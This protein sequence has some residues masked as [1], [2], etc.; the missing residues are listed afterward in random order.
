MERQTF[1]SGDSDNT[2]KEY[3]HTPLAHSPILLH[4]LSQLKHLDLD[5]P[6]AFMFQYPLI[7]LSVNRRSF[8]FIDKVAVASESSGGSSRWS[9]A[10]L[11]MGSVP[12]DVAVCTATAHQHT[13]PT[14]E[15]RW[16]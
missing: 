15:L 12:G 4:L 6:L 5:P 1:S 8:E 3:R 13:A 2:R 10:D 11:E 9:F 7:R 16:R 14:S